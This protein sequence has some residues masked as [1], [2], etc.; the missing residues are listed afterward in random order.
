MDADIADFYNHRDAQLMACKLDATDHAD[1]IFQPTPGRPA[2][3]TRHYADMIV[4]NAPDKRA[5]IAWFI[6][7]LAG[8]TPGVRFRDGAPAGDADWD[9]LITYFRAE[10]LSRRR[11][12][13]GPLRV[14]VPGLPGVH[15]DWRSNPALDSCPIDGGTRGI[16]TADAA[17]TR[18]GGVV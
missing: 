3:Y 6:G 14:E 2:W 18:V 16:P 15:V 5:D 1:S 7:T 13:V 10:I 8:R 9:S 4:A 17:V 11:H 12:L